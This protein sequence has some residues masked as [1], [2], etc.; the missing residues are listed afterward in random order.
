MT[1]AVWQW[2]VESGNRVRLFTGHTGP[3]TDMKL[4]DAGTSLFTASVDCTGEWCCVG[5]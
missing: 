1:S 2:H 3:L 4:N 5:A